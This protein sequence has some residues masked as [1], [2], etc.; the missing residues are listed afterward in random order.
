MFKLNGEINV[1]FEESDSIFSSGLIAETVLKNGF[2]KLGFSLGLICVQ[3]ANGVFR[4]KDGH[5]FSEKNQIQ[6]INFFECR[7][8]EFSSDMII[9]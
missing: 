1:K 6:V 7:S 8:T 2:D 9:N 4:L 3:M 5:V